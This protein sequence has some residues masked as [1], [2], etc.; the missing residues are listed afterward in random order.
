RKIP[1]DMVVQNIGARGL[2]NVSFT[3]PQ[4]EL[5]ET[6]TAAEE[7]VQ[8]LGS[9]QVKHGTNLSKVSVVGRGMTTHTG[10]AAQ[11]FSALGARGANIGMIP[12]S[13]SKIWVLVD[14]TQAQNARAAVPGGFGLDREQPALPPVG[15]AQPDEGDESDRAREERE[16]DVVGRLAHMEDIVVSEVELDGEQSLVT[17]RM[18]PDVPGVASVVFSANARAGIMVDMIVQ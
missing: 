16:R 7:A 15:V 8:V 6:L 11:M 5:A 14:R 1:I 17:L 13:D 10:V 18:L 4:E 3:V 12:R 2:A 9:G